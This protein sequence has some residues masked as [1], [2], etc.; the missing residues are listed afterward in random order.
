MFFQKTQGNYTMA[1]YL[2]YIFINENN[3]YTIS[4]INTKFGN[5]DHLLVEYTLNFG[6]KRKESAIWRFDKNCFK[7]EL[8][9]KEIL[10][11]IADLEDVKN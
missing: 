9:K 3:A 11:E 5:S 10:K 1:T 8:L 7:N 2:D 4:Q 6:S